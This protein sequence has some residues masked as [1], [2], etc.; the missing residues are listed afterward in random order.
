[1]F[2]LG[3][4]IFLA[5]FAAS[6]VAFTGGL[7]AIFGEEKIRRASHFIVSFAIGALFTVAILKLIPEAA[8]MADLKQ[9]SIF[10]LAGILLFFMLE[11][12]ILWHNSHDANQIRSYSYLI[13][14]GDFVHNFVDGVIIALAFLVDTNLGIATTA[15]V[16]LHEIPQEIGDFGILIRGGF[17]VKKALWYNFLSASS[18]IIAAML[19]YA[20]GDVLM[21]FLPI[22]LALSAGAFIY[23]AAVDL[24]PELRESARLSHTLIQ[25]LFILVGALMVILPEFIL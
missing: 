21:P 15:A 25:I 23:I 1:M 9:V 20:F 7:M 3:L 22:A 10:V 17:S 24:M 11:K 4:T 6:L 19:T 14:Y 16:I 18:V 13:L 8:E 12:F 2:T 5:S